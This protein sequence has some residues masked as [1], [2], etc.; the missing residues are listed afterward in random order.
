MT[1]W[2]VSRTLPDDTGI[3]DVL[4]GL[5]GYS[6]APTLLQAILWAG[7]LGVGLTLFLRPARGRISAPPSAP[8]A[9]V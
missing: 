1:L 5:V 9:A 8:A 3:G 6:A 7:F 4:H 2:N